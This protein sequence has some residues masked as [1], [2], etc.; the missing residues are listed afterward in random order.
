MKIYGRS[1]KS[2]LWAKS[3]YY[4]SGFWLRTATKLPWFNCSCFLS[5]SLNF[6]LLLLYFI[7]LSETI[8]KNFG[9]KEEPKE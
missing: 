3:G 5:L 2:S 1:S 9:W 6:L 7:V 8:V 4:N